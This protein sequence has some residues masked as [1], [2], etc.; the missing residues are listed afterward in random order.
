M[1]GEEEVDRVR[2]RKY[3]YL[4]IW[5]GGYF[6]GNIEGGFR[7]GEIVGWSKDIEEAKVFRDYGEAEEIA[8]WLQSY[9]IESEVIATNLNG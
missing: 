3:G 6:C 2:A 8:N 4:V 7:K 1:K 5:D 9:E